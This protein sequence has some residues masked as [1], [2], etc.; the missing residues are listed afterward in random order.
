VGILE[1]AMPPS[2]RFRRLYLAYLRRLVPAVGAIVSGR[3][4]AYGY[5]AASIQGFPE[6]SQMTAAIGQAGFARPR[7]H[8]FFY[9]IAALY[10]A[11]RPS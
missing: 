1:F 7:H 2:R 11:Q 3:R 5:L 6:Q 10:V 4:S 8:D 9:G